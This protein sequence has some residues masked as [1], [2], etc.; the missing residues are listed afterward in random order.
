MVEDMFILYSIVWSGVPN[1][2]K[3]FSEWIRW[4]VYYSFIEVNSSTYL[5]LFDYK[6]EKEI[7]LEDTRFSMNNFGNK[8]SISLNE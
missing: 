3:R 8:L 2:E 1:I 4:R 5:F 7:L 6:L